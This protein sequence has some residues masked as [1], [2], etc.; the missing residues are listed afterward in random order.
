MARDSK[1]FT[2]PNGLPAWFQGD[3]WPT[4]AAEA[5]QKARLQLLRRL[6]RRLAEHP[7]NYNG[8]FNTV[9][10]TSLVPTYRDIVKQP[11][12]FGTIRR[13]IEAGQY[14]TIQ[15]MATDVRLVF[16]NAMLFNP[17]GHYVH[18]CAQSLSVHFEDWLA[19]VEPAL[20]RVLRVLARARRL[21]S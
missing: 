4:Q 2:W 1:R 18:T 6:T 16:T 8:V 12:D 17:P 7:H 10:D 19:T 3:W 21:L 5:V 11:M 14:A 15:A 20:V 13:R 9:V